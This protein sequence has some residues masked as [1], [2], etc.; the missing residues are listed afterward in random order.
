M[1]KVEAKEGKELCREAGLTK[2]TQ[3][4]LFFP[5]LFIARFTDE[6][7]RRTNVYCVSELVYSSALDFPGSVDVFFSLSLFSLFIQCGRCA[8]LY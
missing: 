1:W 3:R 7:K 8:L 4:L 6:I 2:K 5:S